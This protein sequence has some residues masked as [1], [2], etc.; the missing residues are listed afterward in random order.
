[1][2]L[3]QI[4]ESIEKRDE[5]DRNKKEGA[6]KVAP[7]ALYLDTSNLTIEDVGAIILKQIS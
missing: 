3:E 5:I 7:D 2:T 4:K 6:L 1:M